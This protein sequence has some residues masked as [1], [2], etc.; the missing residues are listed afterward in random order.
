M[1]FTTIILAGGLGKR[2]NSDIPKVVHFIFN[3]PMIYYV[4]SNALIVGATNIL[5]VVGKYRTLIESEINK[6]F[7]PIELNKIHYINQPEHI[8][9]DKV[10]VLGTGDAVK[11]C[12]PFFINNNTPAKT[13]V[14]ILSGDVPLIT[15]NTISQLLKIKNSLLI[16]QLDVPFGCGRI[17]LTEKNTI[18]KIIE[19]KDCT[20]T[21]RECKL[22]NCGIYNVDVDV[23][24]NCIPQ[25]TNNNKSQ[26]YYLTDLIEVGIRQNVDF[27][28]YI[29]P[30]ESQLE[31]L[32]INTQNELLIANNTKL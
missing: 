23:L 21:E 18:C 4:I 26:E 6:L 30:R 16:T 15:T 14:L 13:Q 28:Y 22:V 1:S 11:C 32:N 3:K 27:L 2:M 7:D 29:L 24:L 5:I 31:I 19:E 20:E 25:I 8:L 17:F 9:N 10:K 12:L